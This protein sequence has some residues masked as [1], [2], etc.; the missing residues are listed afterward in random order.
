VTSPEEAEICGFGGAR[1]IGALNT[2]LTTSG[3]PGNYP[4]IAP[5]VL[6]ANRYGFLAAD[7]F[8][9]GGVILFAMSGQPP[10]HE[11]RGIRALLHAASGEIPVPESHPRLPANDPLWTLM[12]RCWSFEPNARPAMTDVLKELDREI[13]KRQITWN[14]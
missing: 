2:G 3:R 14:L 5:E 7:V 6:S 4:Y 10:F 1:V 8:A 11:I 12:R 9:F 13:D